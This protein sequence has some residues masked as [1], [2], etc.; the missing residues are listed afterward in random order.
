M[1]NI[2]PYL[3]KNKKKP[4]LVYTT[5]GDF[6]K[7]CESVTSACREFKLD[8]STVSKI[9]RGCGKSTKGYTIKYKN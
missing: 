6:V 8:S 7:E 9:L 3:P 2:D 4:V 1:D 5:S